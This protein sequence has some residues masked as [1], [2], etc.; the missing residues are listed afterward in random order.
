M[1]IQAARR[2]SGA[3]NS[4]RLWVIGKALDVHGLGRVRRRD[5]R[6]YVLQLGASPR[7]W[8]R[9]IKA[10]REH[11]FIS[12]VQKGRVWW[13]I[14]PSAGRIAL[15]MGLQSIGPRKVTIK[16]AELIGSGWRARVESTLEHGKQISREQI[17]KAYNIPVRTQV[18]RAGQL[19][20]EYKRTR[21]Y[22]KSAMKADKLD[23]IKEYS[24]HKAPFVSGNGFIYWRLPDARHSDN[25]LHSAQ[26]RARKVNLFIRQ[27]AENQKG[28]SYMRR[29]LTSDF[30]RGEWIRLFNLTEAQRKQ[31]ERRI[32]KQDRRIMELYQRAGEAISSAGIWA[33]C[34][35]A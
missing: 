30:Q 1:A 27:H 15:E 32:A 26:G 24:S 18:Y 9:W 28:L 34:P 31:S 5:L 21:N 2:N 25:V 11:G 13:V 22:S 4:W 3:G 6:A 29:A 17:Q 10:A 35:R 16:A 19:G 23:G 14:L 20:D 33:H 7:Q 8:Q 12:D